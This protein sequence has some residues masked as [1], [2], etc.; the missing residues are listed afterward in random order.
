MIHGVILSII[1]MVRWSIVSIVAAPAIKLIGVN[2]A[3]IAT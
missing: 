3:S 2:G 1:K